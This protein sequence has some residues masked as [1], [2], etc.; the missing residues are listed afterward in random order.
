MIISEFE[1]DEEAVA[2][3]NDGEFSLCASVFSTDVV[4]STGLRYML[5]QLCRKEG[6]VEA[7]VMAG[8][9]GCRG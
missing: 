8:S 9:V 7:A 6:P 5:R 2:L 4:I 1:T 3:A